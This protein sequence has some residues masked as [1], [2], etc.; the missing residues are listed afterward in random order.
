MTHLKAARKRTELPDT[1]SD[2]TVIA[3]QSIPQLLE[4]RT[5]WEA[6]IA[7]QEQR[8]IELRAIRAQIRKLA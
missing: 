6:E 3:D 8:Q 1:L 5:K 4:L 2:G 7:L